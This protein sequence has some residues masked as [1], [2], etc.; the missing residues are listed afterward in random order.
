MAGRGPNGHS[1]IFE[2]SDGRW[3]GW[4]N[5][6][7]HP[8]KVRN[9]RHVSSRTRSVVMVKV[10]D[11][12]RLR[13]SAAVSAHGPMTVAEWLNTW[14]THIAVLRVRARTLESYETIVSRHIVPAIGSRPLEALEPEHVERLYADLLNRGLARSTVVR[15]HRVL[16]RALKVAHRRQ[17]IS[18]EVIRFVDPPTHPRSR[19][20]RPLTLDEARR[21]LVVA[22]AQRNAA[23]WS[24]ALALGLRQ[25]EALALQWTDIDIQRETLTVRR[26]VHRV[27]GVGLV[28]EDPKSASSRRT[29]ALPTELADAL[30][31]HRVTQLADQV[32]AARKW[33]DNDLVFAQANGRP[34]DKNSDWNNWRRL[35]DAAGV[36]HVRLHDARHTAATLLL[37]EHVHPRVVMELL[38]H[39]QVRTTLDIYSHVM[40]ALARDA[41]DRMGAVLLANLVS[42]ADHDELINTPGPIGHLMH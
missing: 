38:G 37:V 42:T 28:Y 6:G 29:I 16:S 3:H 1:S 17:H 12:E 41:A 26:T 40:P 9:R 24:V 5:M 22:T 30:R 21:V 20:A 14:L 32:A 34:I 27:K 15:V 35:L 31:A 8:E 7:P 25:S 23:R 10:R 2:G 19:V 4:V 18:R 33:Q 11:L 13:D 39:S 36:D